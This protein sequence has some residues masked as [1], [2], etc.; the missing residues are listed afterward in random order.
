M[1]IMS[2]FQ[3]GETIHIRFC[4]WGFVIFRVLVEK[5][6]GKNFGEELFVVV[7]EDESLSESTPHIRPFGPPSPR[8]RPPPPFVGPL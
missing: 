3:K 5:E 4:V 1:M 7:K 6:K 2:S 8:G